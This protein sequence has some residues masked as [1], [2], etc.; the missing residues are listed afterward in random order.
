MRN[1]IFYDLETTGTNIVFDQIMQFGAVLTDRNLVELDRF[2][3]RCRLLPW[4]V[5]APGAL[6]V[7][8]T[9]V[10]LLDD[11][12]LP[13]FYSMMRAIAQQLNAWGRATFVGYNS[14]PFDE[15]FLQR[16]FWQA[17]LPPYVTVTGGN[18]RLDLLV[19]L[20]AA[21]TFRSSVLIVPH[22]DDGMPTYRLD[23]LAPF[24]G[25]NAHHA[26]DAMGDVEAT[27][28]LARK[29]KT[30]FSELW[31]K[32]SGRASKSVI[33]SLL[34]AGEPLFLFHHGAKPSLSCYYRVDD[35]RLRSHATLARL[36]F[37]WKGASILSVD[38]SGAMRQMLRRVALNKAPVVLTLEEAENFASVIPTDLE[39]AQASFLAS[40]RSYCADL[41]ELLGPLSA[42]PTA[43][44]AQV[45]ETIFDGFASN[46]DA[47]LMAEFHRAAP[48][49]QLEI[50]KAF[51][52]V[53]FRR[54]AM[55]ILYVQ[56]PQIL[57]L[58]ETRPI[59]AGIARRLEGEPGGQ[60]WRS[61]GDARKELTSCSFKMSS[62][63][64]QSISNWLAERA[65]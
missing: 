35:G 6:L 2:E 32:L 47:K 20:R 42:S 11:P 40:D 54:L 23:V 7:T 61:L 14:I 41:A 46:C 29:L 16:A 43:N 28:F 57:T 62:E 10:R 65:V 1:F 51:E 8:D 9:D 60:P 44:G 56:A 30:G 36:S 45:E 5:P 15:P 53:R 64:K 39:L 59:D 17:L 34:D 49:E 18:S 3:I 52:D 37:D 26:H 58:R 25:F 13:D 4:I 24:N 33:S 19:I 55:R 12:T 21:S 38:N 22:R 27:L 50:A 63:S 48:P 31:E